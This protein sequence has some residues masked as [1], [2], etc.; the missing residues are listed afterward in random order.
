MSRFSSLLMRCRQDWGGRAVGWLWT[1]RK[2]AQ[3][4]CCSAKLFLEELT[5]LRAFVIIR[6]S[7][8]VLRNLPLVCCVFV[9]DPGVSSLVRWWCYDDYQA[10]GTW[11]HIWRKSH[12]LRGFNGCTWGINSCFVSVFYTCLSTA[13]EVQLSDLCEKVY[14]F[15]NAGNHSSKSTFSSEGKCINN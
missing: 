10:R 14:S 13:T 8:E 1:T 12:C 5:L 3:I 4:S 6:G 11:I 7:V 2:S 15:E 9:F